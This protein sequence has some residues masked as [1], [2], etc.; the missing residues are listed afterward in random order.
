[1]AHRIVTAKHKTLGILA[2]GGLFATVL[3]MAATAQHTHY[4]GARGKSGGNACN[5]ATLACASKVTP[6]AASDG[7]L[8]IVFQAG[9]RVLVSR[10]ANLGR[11]FT[12]PV[13]VTRET[14]DLDWGPDARPKIS[15][16]AAGR[17]HVAFAVFKDKQF[18][19]RVFHVV[20]SDG[21]ATFSEPRAVTE[22]ATSQRF[23]T[24]TLLPDGRLFA[25][26]LDKRNRAP[27][28][29]RGETYAGAALAFATLAPAASSFGE[30][31]IAV[32]QTCECCRISAAVDSE[33][34]AVALF[35]NVFGGGIRDHAVATF[36][37]DGTVSLVRV[38]ADDWKADA[39][40]HHGPSLAIA[41]DGTRHVV[42]FT[43][44]AARKGLFYAS[45]KGTDVPFS[46]PIPVG[47]SKRAPSR[48]AI[49]VTVDRV[50]MVWKEFDGREASVAGMQSADGGRNWSAP[51]TIASTASE[52]DH[53]MLVAAG[54]RA[55]LSWQTEAEGY[56]LIEL[57]PGL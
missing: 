44:G 24:L 21:G 29:V 25:A 33:G 1:M 53:P 7:S 12:P 3:P 28:K 22:D 27:A 46:Q 55:V 41:P 31:A 14:A 34:R 26:W 57:E 23:E 43:A 20:S 13:A 36:L 18:N 10:T 51:R 47:N 2:I 19:G 42:W 38:S 50:H 8:W 17:V 6:A 35:R 52:S 4:G 40:P 32:D 11:T 45:S 54:T 9:G 15:I 5:E 39:C 30:T 37:R 48:P 16:D 49:L 56:R